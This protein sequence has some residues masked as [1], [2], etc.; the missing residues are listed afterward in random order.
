MY[1][2]PSLSERRLAYCLCLH[3]KP[4]T[5]FVGVVNLVG[6]CPSFIRTTNSF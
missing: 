4:A 1:Q 6:G 5:V 2:D 3:V